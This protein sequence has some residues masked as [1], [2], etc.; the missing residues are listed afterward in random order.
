MAGAAL[1]MPGWPGSR[2]HVHAAVLVQVSINAGSARGGSPRAGLTSGRLSAGWA[3]R[4]L[5]AGGMGNEGEERC[6]RERERERGSRER[7]S[8]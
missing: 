4:W 6:R 7:E 3:G 1:V 5:F 2:A 8:F